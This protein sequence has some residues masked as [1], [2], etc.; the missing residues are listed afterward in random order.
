MLLYWLK[1]P[2][3]LVLHPKTAARLRRFGSLA[4]FLAPLLV[5]SALWLSVVRA[6]HTPRINISDEMVQQGRDS[7]PDAVLDEL[8]DFDFLQDRWPSKPE[9]MAAASALLGGQLR[10]ESCAAHI[11]L[12]FSAAE[13]EQIPAPCDLPLAGFFVPDVFL[14]AYEASG[15]EE[16]LSTAQAFI[17]GAHEYEEKAWLPRGQFWNDHA[18]SARVSVL[19]NFWRLYR[20][21]PSYRPDV[22][23]QVMSMVARSEALLAKPGLFTVATNHGIMQNL[24]LWHAS[25]AFPALPHTREYQRLALAR[26]NDQMKFYVSE[27]G[28]I[29]EHSAGYQPF[30][31]ERLAWAFRYLDLMHQPAPQEWIDKYER[32]Q[33]FYGTLRRPDGSLPMFGDTDAAADQSGPRVASFAPDRRAQRLLYQDWKPAEAVNLYPVSGCSIWWDRLDSWPHLRDLSQTVVTWSNFSGHGHKHADEMSVLFWAGGQNW[34]SNI[35]YW[36]YESQWRSTIESW[37]GSNAP[38]LLGESSTASR[39]TRLMSSGA[40]DNLTVLDLQRTGVD[41]Y[42]ARRQVIHWK[43]DFWLVLDSSSGNPGSRTSTIWTTSPDIRWQQGA[44]GAFVL[45]DN[46][47]DQRLNGFVLGSPGTEQKL[48]RGSTHPFAG[49]Q[50]EGWEWCASLGPGDRTTSAEFLDGNAVDLAKAGRLL[51]SGRSA[52]NDQ[53]D[54]CREL[55]DAFAGDWNRAP[56]AGQGAGA[57]SREGEGHDSGIEV[58]PQTSL[59]NSRSWISSLPPPQ[60]NILASSKERR[61]G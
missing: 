16:F 3:I 53:L 54:R 50:V 44:E 57:S 61:G 36:P 24:A 11:K 40:S 45:E 58:A 30:G 23:R 34:W 41:H 55:G 15:R 35:G 13:L 31:L 46:R 51:N 52:S 7:P 4:S 1:D 8:K 39:T 42:T 38:H 27:E 20:H 29:L 47:D 19:A 12:P 14:R 33:K 49:W 2:P 22:A 32:A 56:A 37:P 5:I 21:S 10:F 60:R 17:L 6:Y 25:L 28:V 26:M 43:P 9:L 59:L 18:I 48:F